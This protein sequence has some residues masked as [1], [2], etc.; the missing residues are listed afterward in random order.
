[1]STSELQFIKEQVPEMFGTIISITDKIPAS[2]LEPL[3]GLWIFAIV[4]PGEKVDI[5]FGNVRLER[6][7][8]ERI[9][10]IRN[11]FTDTSDGLTLP[12]GA[13]FLAKHPTQPKRGGNTVLL[14]PRCIRALAV[15]IGESVE[16]LTDKVD[17]FAAEMAHTRLR[18][19]LG[20]T[21]ESIGLI[22]EI[23]PDTKD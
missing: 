8:E 3:E 10:Q 4:T 20:I 23:P 7:A 1:M 18:T 15:L 6:T 22:V 19:L 2:T 5:H 13:V 14:V 21:P 16:V 9:T 12:V 11:W 17:G